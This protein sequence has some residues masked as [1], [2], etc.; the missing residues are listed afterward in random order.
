M[1]YR[2]HIIFL[3]EASPAWAHKDTLR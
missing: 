3:G 1:A 2:T